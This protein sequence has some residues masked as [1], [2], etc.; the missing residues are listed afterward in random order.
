MTG[1]MCSRKDQE[2]TFVLEDGRVDGTADDD[3]S[4]DVT[5]RQHTRHRLKLTVLYSTVPFT[6]TVQHQNLLAFESELIAAETRS[7]DNSQ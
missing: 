3:E 4:Q 6:L 1:A 7:G 2:H 5:T